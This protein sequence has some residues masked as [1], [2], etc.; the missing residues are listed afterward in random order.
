[1]FAFIS[2]YAPIKLI[3]KPGQHIHINK[4]RLHIFRKVCF[5]E[6]LKKDD[7]FFDL[8][9][10]L[11]D[12][13]DRADWDSRCVSLAWDWV[14]I[15]YSSMGI[16]RELSTSLTRHFFS[17]FQKR[18][19]GRGEQILGKVMYSVACL[20]NALYHQ[21]EERVADEDTTKLVCG[22]FPILKTAKHQL[23][24]AEAYF[25]EKSISRWES[26]K[27]DADEGLGLSDD[28]Y[29]C[30][31]C[32]GELSCYYVEALFKEKKKKGKIEKK[33]VCVCIQCF[34]Q[35][36]SLFDKKE[37]TFWRRLKYMSCDHLCRVI[38]R[39]ESCLKEKGLHNIWW[40]THIENQLLQDYKVTH[41]I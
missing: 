27:D 18:K 22:I 21:L 19:Y 26:M 23:E 14:F 32:F 11:K 20:S 1:M 7:C 37:Y 39:F 31:Q 5:Y 17:S 33:M 41:E 9:N 16:A 15:G 13:I 40:Q 28:R 36:H 2:S 3:L 35:E 30:G 34:E 12:T 38:K 6:K 10:E 4:M 8:R 25:K 24:H 29:E